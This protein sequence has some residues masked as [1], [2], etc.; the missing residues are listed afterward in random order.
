MDD[1][2]SDAV[3]SDSAGKPACV[4]SGL[5]S[6]ASFVRPAAIARPMVIFAALVILGCA[7]EKLLHFSFCLP[8]KPSSSGFY[9]T[10][11]TLLHFLQRTDTGMNLETDIS[12][13]QFGQVTVMRSTS[14][15]ISP[16][17]HEEDPGQWNKL[18]PAG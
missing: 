17:Y 13:L 15:P 5:E 4:D 11:K 9:S 1:T 8:Q 18:L 2:S 7:I 6:R 16:A 14:F 12:F 10:L 3:S